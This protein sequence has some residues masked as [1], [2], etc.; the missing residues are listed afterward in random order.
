LA[1]P[2]FPDREP[3]ARAFP[4]GVISSAKGDSNMVRHTARQKRILNF[5]EFILGPFIDCRLFSQLGPSPSAIKKT[6]IFG[7]QEILAKTMPTL[8]KIKFDVNSV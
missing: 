5:E 6:S 2:L 8:I 7:D 1:W 3:E 4:S